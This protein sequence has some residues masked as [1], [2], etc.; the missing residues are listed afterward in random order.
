MLQT[1]REYALARLAETGEL[2]E[3]RRR[4]LAHYL[5][6]ALD[7]SQGLNGPRQAELLDRLEAAYPDIRAALE[8]ACHQGER[9]GTCLDEGLRL[10]VTVGPFWQRRGWLAEGVLQLDRLL[11][12][13][14]TQRHASPSQIRA[15]AVLAACTLACFQ[16]N[17]AR[18]V[19]LA[20]QGIELCDR[21][22]DHHGL[23]R[24]HRFLG[25]AVLVEGD[26]AAAE[27]HF[28]RQLTEASQAGDVAGQ[29]DAYNML[30]QAARHRGEFRR[31]RS[32]LW[33]AL[34]LFRA[35]DDPDGVAV[36]LSSLAEVA[37]DA[38]RPDLARRSYGA[39]L[40][41]HT[42]LGNKRQM[43]FEL[44]GFAAVAALEGD[45]RQALVYLGASQALHEETGG[46]P[47]PAEKAITDRIL[48][49][50]VA[51]LPAR[52]RED[53]VRQG[54]DQPL[55]A[56]IARVLGRPGRAERQAALSA[57]AGGC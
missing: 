47:L 22:G 17:Y 28:Q 48:A 53:A 26:G 3:V 36:A 4:H 24:A 16:G 46:P 50:V 19:E 43:A 29:A 18:T 57:S 25:E 8:F 31:A 45:A 39:A 35:A 14:D 33:Y 55:R 42:A 49:P 12:L 38:G 56:T 27:P 13:D 44:E 51:P 10:A 7:A 54:R 37:R 6:L 9:Y 30:G 5:T 52:E 20:R 15:P 40:R 1:V 32:L 2:D 41:R 21:L 34:K 11:A 23:S